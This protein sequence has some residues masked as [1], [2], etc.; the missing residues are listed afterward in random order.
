MA[1]RPYTLVIPGN[2]RSRAIWREASE[3]EAIILV[4]NPLLLHHVLLAA[5]SEFGRDIRRVIFDGSLDESQLL[6]FLS[7]LPVEFRGDVMMIRPDGTAFLSSAGR[8]EGRHLYELGA[9]DVELWLVA[10]IGWA[11][12]AS[13][14]PSGSTEAFTLALAV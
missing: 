10:Q 14:Q 8:A 13:G 3:R 5:S 6:R 9:D 4:E 11:V 12:A 1:D 2:P 7:S